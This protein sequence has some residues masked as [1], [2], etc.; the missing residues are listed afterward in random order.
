MLSAAGGIGRETSSSLSVLG[1]RIGIAGAA[2]LGLEVPRDDKRLLVIL[3]TEGCFADGVE[4]TTGHTVGHPT[5]RSK[6]TEKSL[7]RLSTQNLSG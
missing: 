4:V 2:S 3:E 6:I 1:V 7:P 5:L